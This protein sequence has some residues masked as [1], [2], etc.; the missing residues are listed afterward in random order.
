MAPIAAGPSGP[1]IMVSTTVIV[2]QH[3]SARATGIARETT[4][5]TSTQSSCLV[6]EARAVIF[7]PEWHWQG[8]KHAET[9]WRIVQL[10]VQLR[11]EGHQYLRFPAAMPVAG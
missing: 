1:T 7:K 10:V 8:P 9:L 4:R 5:R 6:A 11:C 3:S 2:I